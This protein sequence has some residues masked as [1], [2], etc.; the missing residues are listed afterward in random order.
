MRIIMELYIY[1]MR[2]RGCSPGAQP[3]KGLDSFTES[4][5]PKY[6]D[7]LYYSRKLTDEEVREYE[8][9]YLGQV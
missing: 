8:L 6:Y 7:I 4:A 1:G 9:D 2:L 3:K 5:D